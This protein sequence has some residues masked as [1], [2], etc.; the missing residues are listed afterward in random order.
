MIVPDLNLQIYAYNLGAPDHVRARQW[1]EDIMRRLE[2]V[3]MP[4]SV[5]LGFIRLMT[6]Q[7]VIVPPMLLPDAVGEVKRWLALPNVTL[8]PITAQHWDRLEKIGWTG[9][10]VSDAHLAAIAMEHGCELHTADADFAKCTGLR[11]KNPL[12]P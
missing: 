8:L 5:A 12:V 1:W 3:G 9:S 7:K 10:D 4:L 2:P 11:W 6:N